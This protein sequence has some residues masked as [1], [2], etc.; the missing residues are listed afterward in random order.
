[1]SHYGNYKPNFE[2]KP[3]EPFLVRLRRFYKGFIMKLKQ[4]Y[5]IE[6]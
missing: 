3:N 1:M 4:L 2:L 5:G 6:D